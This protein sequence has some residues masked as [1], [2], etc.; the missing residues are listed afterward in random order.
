MPAYMIAALRRYRRHLERKEELTRM[1]QLDLDY[2]N[3]R[4]GAYDV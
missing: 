1:Q 4:L 2:I 3:D